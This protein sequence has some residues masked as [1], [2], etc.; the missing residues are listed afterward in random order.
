MNV[1]EQ[2]KKYNARLA[3]KGYSQVEG[4]DIGEIFFHVSKLDSI[5][6]I[7]SLA[8]TIDLEIE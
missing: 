1:V 3:T 6:V 7:M 4:V 2:V 8:S 5:R